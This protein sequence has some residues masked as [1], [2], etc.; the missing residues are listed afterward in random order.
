MLVSIDNVTVR[1]L[2]KVLFEDLSLGIEKGEQWALLG[3]SGAG[4]TAM[5]HTLYGFFNI[6]NGEVSYPYLKQY[7][8]DLGI[9]DPLFT[10]DKMI[11]FV[12]Q[13]AHFKNKEN[14]AD[15]FYQQRYHAYYSEEAARVGEYLEKANRNRSGLL[16]ERF[17][18]EWIME[19]L[20]LSALLEKTLI[21]L[22]NGETRRL[23]IAEAL[24][25]QPVLL[26]MD[27]PF[28]GLDKETRPIL[29]DLLH[30]IREKGTSVVMA[31]SPREIPETITNVLYLKDRKVIFNGSIQKFQQAD[32]EI[33]NLQT[34]WK[35]DEEL[36]S[37]IEAQ[38]RQSKT[39]FEYAIKLKNIHVRSGGRSILEDID[40]EVKKGEKWA[41]V[42]HNGAGKSTLLSLINGDHPQAYANDIQLFDRKRGSGESIWELKQRIGYMS[43]EMHQFFKGNASV[44]EVVL[45]GLYDVMHFQLSRAEKEEIKLAENGLALLDLKKYRREKYKDLSVGEQRLVLLLRGMIKNPPLLILDEPCQGLDDRQ[46]TH[47]KNV[48]NIICDRPEKTMLY[49]SHYKEDIPIIVSKVLEL[50]D[51]RVV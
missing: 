33:D 30:E 21:Q 27:N 20:Q 41:L 29:R 3:G 26:L 6:T 28:V 51:G 49:V 10:Y 36:L 17:S 7:K 46:K 34:Q 14:M 45:S 35:P 8:E 47:F 2:N 4:K 43:P 40:W 18:L 13:Q 15:F 16:P 44:I 24:L 37:L 42:G 39:N 48:V 38:S 5:L 22:S 12:R 1:H 9:D 32:I 19:K 25:E 31:T 11:A 50:R 23:M